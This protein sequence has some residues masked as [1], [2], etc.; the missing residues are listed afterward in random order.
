VSKIEANSAKGKLV[1]N[2]VETTCLV[3]QVIRGLVVVCLLL[4][5][6]SIVRGASVPGSAPFG[7]GGRGLGH[8]VIADFDGDQKPDFATVTVDQ[9]HIAVTEYSI[10]LQ[11]SHG[12]ESSIGLTARSGGLQLFS[13]DVNGDDILDVVVRTALDSNLVAVLINDGRGNF[14]LAKPELFPAL[15]N[16]PGS[17]FGLETRR[18]AERILLLPS[19]SSAGDNAELELPGRTKTAT[20]PLSARKKREFS[21][22]F[23]HSKFGR[24]P[25]E[26]Q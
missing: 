2:I 26:V 22:F 14:T 23:C 3:K 18:L 7:E 20:E 9:S 6:S 12:L 17:H 21:N 11:L 10:H 16:E 25:P 8:F 15:E 19:R 4:A 5:G 24:S 13:R 1:P